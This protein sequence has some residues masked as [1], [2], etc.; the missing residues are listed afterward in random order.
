ME[1]PQIDAWNCGDYSRIKEL[2]E[3]GANIH[4]WNDGPIRWASRS[5]DSDMVK[6]LVDKGAN[7]HCVGD[8]PLRWA[9][10]YGHLDVVK[11]LVERGANVRAVNDDALRLCLEKGYVSTFTYLASFYEKKELHSILS[12]KENCNLTC[13]YTL[14]NFFFY[15]KQI[16]KDWEG[17]IGLIVASLVWE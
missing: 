6:Y 11:Y 2:I 17:N 10:Q 1:D 8:L 7:I 14:M 4:K 5:G 16:E 9:A 12:S 15:Q 3:Q 13:F